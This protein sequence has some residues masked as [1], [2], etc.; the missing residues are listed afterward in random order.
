MK[1]WKSTNL[2]KKEWRGWY[3]WVWCALSPV[4]WDQQYLRQWR[5]SWATMMLY[6]I[7]TDRLSLTS[8]MLELLVKTCPLLLLAIKL[9]CLTSILVEQLNMKFFRHLIILFSA[10]SCA[11]HYS[12][13]LRSILLYM[14]IHMNGKWMAPWVACNKKLKIRVV[15]HSKKQLLSATWS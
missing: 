5:G 7:S 9:I 6:F 3:K 4:I 13:Y 12:Q 1:L 11:S 15:G 14:G 2:K 10:S 8:F